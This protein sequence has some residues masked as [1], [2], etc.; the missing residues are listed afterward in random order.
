MNHTNLM[1]F[2]Q[3]F[4]ESNRIN[5]VMEYC[6]GFSLVELIEQHGTL[7]EAL[8]MKIVSA[9]LCGLEHMHGQS[10]AHRDL[11]CEN[12]ICDP[13]APQKTKIVDF[14]F[15]KPLGTNNYLSDLCGSPSYV[16]PEVLRKEPYN[17]Q[18][19]LWSLGVVMFACLF[20]QMPFS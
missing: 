10:V 17:V 11:K 8:T 20:G 19:D 2:E 7:D 13:D 14:G 12:I 15:A 6:P 3:T 4:E 1:K 18:C 16:A 9:V 5:I